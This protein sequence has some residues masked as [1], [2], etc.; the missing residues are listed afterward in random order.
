LICFYKSVQT[1]NVFT[2]KYMLF[3]FQCNYSVHELPSRHTHLSVNSTSC[4]WNYY[5]KLMIDTL[6]STSVATLWL[7]ILDRLVSGSMHPVC[8]FGLQRTLY[9]PLLRKLLQSCE[10]WPRQCHK[11][12]IGLVNWWEINSMSSTH[13]RTTFSLPLWHNMKLPYLQF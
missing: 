2:M 9:L 1:S 7:K 13:F 11:L 3:F 12:R 6:I 5:T 8:M 10:Q 4:V